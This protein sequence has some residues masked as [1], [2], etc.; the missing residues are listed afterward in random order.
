MVQPAEVEV[1][2]LAAHP[3]LV[4]DVGDMRWREWGSGEDPAE[5]WTQLT[6]RESGRDR[7]PVSLVAI[8][9]WGRAAGA[10]ALGGS[11]DALTE[12]QRADRTPWLLGLIV[13]SDC[14][15]QGIGR[16][17]VDA[18]EELARERAFSTVW[19]ATG[20]GAVDFYRHC[21]WSDEEELT[22]SKGGWLNHVLSK[23][24]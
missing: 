23:R 22:L 5:A 4:P 6:A 3:H 19:V 13:R 11:D 17:L 14:R 7:L 20:G 8:D 24:L 2:L 12:G 1:A 9:P 18:L 10:V 15:H 16:R 21:G